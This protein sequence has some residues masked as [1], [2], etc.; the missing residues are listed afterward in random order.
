MQAWAADGGCVWVCGAADWEI[1][2]EEACQRAEVEG[3]AID[4]KGSSKETIKKHWEVNRSMVK[5]SDFSIHL[6]ILIYEIIE[7]ILIKILLIK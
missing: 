3:R 1:W 6:I 2:E 7:W 4:P 5:K